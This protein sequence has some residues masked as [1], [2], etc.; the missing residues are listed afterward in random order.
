MSC[1][2]RCPTDDLASPTTSRSSAEP[3]GSSTPPNRLSGGEKFQA[4]LALAL[5]LAELHSRSGSNLG[6]LFLDEGFAALDAAALDAAL[7]VL[8]ARAG[9]DRLVMVIS[10]LHAV[11]EAVD[12]VLWVER[13]TAGSSARWLTPAERDDLMQADP[14]SGL[15][16]LAQ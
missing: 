4:S 11:A 8:R 3:Q 14:A 12:E 5:A 7:E 13:T 16:T 15:Q 6:S 9:S 2:A 1:S 10:H